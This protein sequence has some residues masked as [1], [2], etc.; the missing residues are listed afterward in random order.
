M[1]VPIHLALTPKK[2]TQSPFTTYDG[3]ILAKITA[4]PTVPKRNGWHIYQKAVNSFSGLF[5]PQLLK[6]A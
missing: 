5:S 2:I 6:Q 1:K 4:A 3:S